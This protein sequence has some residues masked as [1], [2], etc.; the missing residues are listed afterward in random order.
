MDLAPKNTLTHL[1]DFELKKTFRQDKLYG[2][3][4]IITYAA[5]AFQTFFTIFT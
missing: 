5:M 4:F 3:P 2:M 1:L